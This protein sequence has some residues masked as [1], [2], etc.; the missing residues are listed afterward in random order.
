MEMAARS[1]SDV[2]TASKNLLRT[3]VGHLGNA[4]RVSRVLAVQ[5]AGDMGRIIPSS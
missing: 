3:L 4:R 5:G 2:R 1:R